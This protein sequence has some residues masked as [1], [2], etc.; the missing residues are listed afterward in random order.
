MIAA[1][2]FERRIDR[3]PPAPVLT[4]GLHRIDEILVATLAR[5]DAV[6]VVSPGEARERIGREGRLASAGTSS[7]GSKPRP[8]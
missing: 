5:Y 4:P 2:D 6:A 8:R 7:A 1:L 3:V